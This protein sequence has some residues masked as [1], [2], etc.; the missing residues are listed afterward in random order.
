MPKFNKE[1]IT[2]YLVLPAAIAAVV[3]YADHCATKRDQMT[4]VE[5]AAHLKMPETNP[6]WSEI[7]DRADGMAYIEAMHKR[8]ALL[9]NQ[10][11]SESAEQSLRAEPERKMSWE[12]VKTPRAGATLMPVPLMIVP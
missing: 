9:Q 2:R 10:R 5:I 7:K 12:T 3:L 1:E 6:T 4:R 11:N 8:L